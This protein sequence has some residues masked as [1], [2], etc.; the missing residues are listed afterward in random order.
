MVTETFEYFDETL[1][2]IG[3]LAKPNESGRF[4]VV[5]VVHDWSG[6]NDFAKQAADRLAEQGYLALAVDMFGHGKIGKTN[7]EKSALIQV[8]LDDRLL[9]LKRL[10]AALNAAKALKQAEDSRVAAIGFCFG[11]LCVLDLARS[12]EELNAVVSFHGLF[13]PTP[14]PLEKIKA[15]VLA[16]HGYDDPM[17]TPDQMLR[18]ANE[19]TAAKADWQINAYGQ[20]M[21]AFMNPQANDSA[22]GT[23]Y[24]PRTAKRAWAAMLM[25]LKETLAAD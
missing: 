11:G 13:L 21:H 9:L 3:Y 16:L 19:M 4:P 6:C 5:L 18:F 23:V 15:S 2:C 10:R 20:T 14:Y 25:F 8:F 12:G 17:V 1:P 22:L 7:E 24:Q